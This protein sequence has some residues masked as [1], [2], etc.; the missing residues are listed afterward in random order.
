MVISYCGTVRYS[1]RLVRPL[2]AGER[3]ALFPGRSLRYELGVEIEKQLSDRHQVTLHTICAQLPT[4]T[5]V[6]M[7]SLMPDA[8]SALRLVPKNG[9]LVTTLATE[10][11]TTPATR[12]AYL[13][14]RKGD[15]CGDIELEDL[16]RQKKPKM[17]DRVKLLVV[18]TR[19]IDSIAHTSTRQALELIPTLVRK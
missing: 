16:I 8:E 12:F 11:A 3:V 13:R 4:Y 15:Q 6:G 5:E 14:S 7:A 18:R 19:D 1:P 10:M 2:E 17:P 9:K